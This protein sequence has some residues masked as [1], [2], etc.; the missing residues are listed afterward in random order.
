[1][2]RN[3]HPAAVPPLPAP[4][5]A[6]APEQPMTSGVTISPP[7]IEIPPP[8]TQADLDKTRFVLAFW[9]EGVRDRN[10]GPWIANI[11]RTLEM[12]PRDIVKL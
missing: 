10:P 5:P 3:R 6:P 7:A 11:E 2:P 9:L 4:D 8:L 1:M 12:L